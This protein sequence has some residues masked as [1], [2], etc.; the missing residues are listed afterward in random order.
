MKQV[1]SALTSGNWAESSGGDLTRRKDRPPEIRF[2]SR[3]NMRAILVAAVALSFISDY[4]F[5]QT[6]RTNPSSSSTSKTIPSASSTSPNS[7]CD[8]TNPTS[9]CYSANAPR[10]PCYSAAAPNAPCSTTTTTPNSRTSPASSPAAATTSQAAVR[11]LT[12]D[13]AKSQIEAKGY[14]KVSGLRKD[15]NGIWRGKAEKDGLPV[16]V[17]LGANGDVTAN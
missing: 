13:Q 8:S 4:G 5:A 6:T 17:S 9:P 1:H 2:N 16:N 12:E 14:S 10:N 7:P 15:A 11:A 3:V